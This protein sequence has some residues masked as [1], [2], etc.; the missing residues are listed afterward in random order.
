MSMTISLMK[1]KPGSFGI[2]CVP[3]MVVQT[4]MIKMTHLQHDVL[5]TAKSWLKACTTAFLWPLTLARPLFSN[6]VNTPRA[7]ASLQ[8][9]MRKGCVLALV[10]L[11]AFTKANYRS[12]KHFWPSKHTFAFCTKTTCSFRSYYNA[13]VLQTYYVRTNTY[14][15]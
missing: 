13:N 9:D 12:S 6:T 15:L 2:R 10:L 14:V 8:P 11:L 4:V 3:S 1:S 5:R 7:T